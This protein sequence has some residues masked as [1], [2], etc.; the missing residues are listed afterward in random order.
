MALRLLINI[1][2]TNTEK[3]PHGQLLTNI[4]INKF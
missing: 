1:F 2:G 3:F 4:L